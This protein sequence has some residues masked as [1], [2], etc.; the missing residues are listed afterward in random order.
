VCVCEIERKRERERVSP[1]EV[2]SEDS[3]TCVCVCVCVCVCARALRHSPKN[4]TIQLLF[5]TFVFFWFV[6]VGEPAPL[7]CTRI[8]HNR[9]RQTHTQNMFCVD[10]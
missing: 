3:C 8:A 10:L 4:R 1:A 2:C 7:E 5:T 9:N 6:I